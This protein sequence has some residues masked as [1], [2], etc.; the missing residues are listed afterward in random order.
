MFGPNIGKLEKRGDVEAL[1]EAL[2]NGRQSVRDDAAAALGRL[3]D[4]RAVEPLITTFEERRGEWRQREDEWWRFSQEHRTPSRILSPT[5]YDPLKVPGGKEV[6][7]AA[8]D[9]YEAMEI[10]SRALASFGEQHDLRAIEFL[11]DAWGDSAES[12]PELAGCLSPDLLASVLDADSPG[13]RAEAARLLGSRGDLTV[14]SLARQ[15]K[16]G[17]ADVRGWAA[18]RLGELG[19]GRAVELLVGALDDEDAETRAGAALALGKLG[20]SHAVEPLI[21]MLKERGSNAM[22]AF[23]TLQQLGAREAEEAFAE[24]APKV[25][26]RVRVGESG[27]QYAGM[28]GD[29][30]EMGWGKVGEWKGTVVA[31][32]DEGAS[33]RCDEVEGEVDGVAPGSMTHGMKLDPRNASELPGDPVHW[34]FEI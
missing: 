3:A 13:A 29:R 17:Y 25:G 22:D 21:G 8:D 5:G 7:R 30:I 2:A 11:L 12:R 27:E 9:A 33:V 26:D 32:S 23:L 18:G 31:V 4:T 20:D 1:I 15:L 34:C 19:D 10:T 6:K 28:P 14:E 16:S 24:G